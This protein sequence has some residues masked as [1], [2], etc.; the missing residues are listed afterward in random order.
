MEPDFGLAALFRSAANPKRLTLDVRPH[1][2]TN[3]N[4]EMIAAAH[5]AGLNPTELHMTDL[6]K[7]KATLDDFLFLVTPGG[8]SHKDV[9]QSAKGSAAKIIFN[10]QVWE[11]HQRFFERPNTLTLGVCN[12]CQ[13]DA[14]LGLVP[15]KG[16]ESV[17][18]PRLITNKSGKFE[19]MWITLKVLDSP[20]ILHRKMA[21]TIIGAWV[22]HKEGRFYFPDET[23]LEEVRAKNLIT[24]T[25]VDHN[26]NATQRYPFNPNGSPY[27][28]AGLTSPDGRHTVCMPHLI[29][30]GFQMW[31][32][33]WMPD[34][35]KRL[36]SS[37]CL[38]IFQNARE[39]FEQY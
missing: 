13:K 26:G 16:I 29:D 5:L 31:Q 7:G 27:G 39:F 20:S 32:W 15:W 12:G 28:I 36:E 23:I 22:A 37:P 11:M 4:E 24:M 19:S 25:Y 1:E 6:I 8:F 38:Q 33:S 9:P 17:K 35:F 2:G 18:Q 14:L 34:E 21:G 30:R 10:E 3:G